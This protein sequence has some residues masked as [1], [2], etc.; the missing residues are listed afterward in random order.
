[1]L[2]SYLTKVDSFAISVPNRMYNKSTD[3]AKRTLYFNPYYSKVRVK[4]YNSKIV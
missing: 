2:I 1:M 4:V 3:I